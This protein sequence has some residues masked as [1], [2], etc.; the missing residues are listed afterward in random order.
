MGEVRDITSA[1]SLRE[2]D[3]DVLAWECSALARKKGLTDEDIQKAIRE[4][5]AR[6]TCPYQFQDLTPEEGQE[7]YDIMTGKHADDD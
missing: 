5:R 3:W 2:C 4:A 6:A 1:R 7:L